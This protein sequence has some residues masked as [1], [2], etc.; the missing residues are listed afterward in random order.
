MKFLRYASAAK[1]LRNWPHTLWKNCLRALPA[2]QLS[3]RALHLL[4]TQALARN[5][6][7]L[8]NVI[9]RALILSEGQEV[10]RPEH[11]MFADSD[12]R[13]LRN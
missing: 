10:I 8:Q 11:L 1:I 7:E 4:K 12:F 3:A 13:D 9:E 2:P 6:R 5:I